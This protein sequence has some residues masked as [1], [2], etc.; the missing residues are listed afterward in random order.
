M[1]EVT[2]LRVGLL[3]NPYA[4]VGG[5]MAL[6]GSD[7]M[8]AQALAA[9]IRPLASLRAKNAILAME[10]LWPRIDWVTGAGA[11]GA[12]VLHELG[13]S[14]SVVYEAQKGDSDLS[15][16]AADSVVLASRL[17]ES[18]LDL[19]LFAG[20]DGTARD[21]LKGMQINIPMLGIPAGVKMQSAVFGVSPLAAG[22]LAVDFLEHS[23]R[24]TSELEV[25]DLDEAL[26]RQE[27]VAP[28]L[29]GYMTVPVNT[30]Y[31][32]G[33]KVRSPDSDAVDA[34]AIAQRITA[35]LKD[36][37]TYLIGPGSTTYT[38]KNRLGLEGSLL[39]VDIVRNRKMVQRD[40]TEMQIWNAI[41]KQ[42]CSLLLSCIGGQG[43]VIGRGNAQLSPRILQ[44]L[45]PEQLTVLA[46]PG[47]LQ[48]LR[49]R[50]F[51]IDSGDAEVDA[52]FSQP[53]HVCTGFSDD[54]WYRI[55]ATRNTVEHSISI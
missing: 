10:S 16:C 41:E 11:L 40:A 12:D 6:K 36:G 17:T 26:L 37:V 47:K 15:S 39:G 32:Q 3:I 42:S 25:M 18:D 1:M 49:G 45:G 22:L 23:R 30:R 27:I 51:Q 9:G 7:G 14:A 13:L 44:H 48:S 29:F 4:G 31:L 55:R 20:G 33:K 8:I 21:V 50:P 19:M 34:S 35:E 43:H 5:P 24:T 2:R 28:Q 54:A 38:V 46:T 52:F 53:V